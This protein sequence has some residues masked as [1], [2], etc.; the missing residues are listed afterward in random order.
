MRL[1]QQTSQPQTW[2]DVVIV[3]TK[4]CRDAKAQRP[5]RRCPHGRLPV[6]ERHHVAHIVHAY[7]PQKLGS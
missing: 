3:N 5:Q 4:L 6:G 1:V 2:D 7:R